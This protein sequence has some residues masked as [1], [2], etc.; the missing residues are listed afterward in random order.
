VLA[1]TSVMNWRILLEQLYC[2]HAIGPA[3]SNY[4]IQVSKNMLEFSSTSSSS[5]CT[6]SVLTVTDKKKKVRRTQFKFLMLL[7]LLITFSP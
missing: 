4:H 2:P 1:S 7:Q 6:V 5:T 3:N